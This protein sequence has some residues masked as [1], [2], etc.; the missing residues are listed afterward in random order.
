MQTLVIFLGL[1]LYYFL[2]SVLL[3]Q[4]TF[5]TPP[6]ALHPVSCS[7]CQAVFQWQSDLPRSPEAAYRLSEGLLYST[8]WDESATSCCIADCSQ[9]PTWFLFTRTPCRW[10]PWSFLPG[11]IWPRKLLTNIF[12]KKKNRKR[13]QDL[14]NIVMVLMPELTRL[15]PT[16]CSPY[17]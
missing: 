2:P 10:G 14:F 3:Y 8:H 4:G 13:A 12:Q 17:P 7:V 1:L 9:S 11:V 16:C 5:S 6:M 15:G